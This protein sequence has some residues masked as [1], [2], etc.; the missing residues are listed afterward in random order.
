MCKGRVESVPE[1]DIL[2]VTEI[3]DQEKLAAALHSQ[4]S[5]EQDLELCREDVMSFAT[6]RQT[7][8]KRSNV[9]CPRI[10]GTRRRLVVPPVSPAYLEWNPTLR[11]QRTC[12]ISLH[13]RLTL[14]HF[15]GIILEVKGSDKSSKGENNLLLCE[16]PPRA[17]SLTS[18]I[19]N[20]RAAKI[21]RLESWSVRL[22][23]RL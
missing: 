14:R 21:V 13:V 10:S 8:A 4:H 3:L 15:H 11:R 22:D 18:T 9:I 12:T 19:G 6:L 20:K 17:D 1:I 2:V 5:I 16:V 23:R 7:R